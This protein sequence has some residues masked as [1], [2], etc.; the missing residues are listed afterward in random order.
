M[1][2]KL[3]STIYFDYIFYMEVYNTCITYPCR[4]R[5]SPKKTGLYRVSQKTWEFSDEFD[6]VFS[7]NSL[8]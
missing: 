6:I 2:M 5:L 8:I 4:S 7:N 1:K 3:I